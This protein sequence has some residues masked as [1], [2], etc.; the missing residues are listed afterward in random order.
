MNKL[1][2]GGFLMA[3]IH[4]VSGRIF[5]GRL[6]AAGIEINPAQGRI[7]FA[8]WQQDN[9]PIQT[10]RERTSLEKSTLTSMLDRLEEAGLVRRRPSSSD[11]RQLLIERTQK[12]RALEGAYKAV[13][14]GMAEVFYRGFK[15]EEIERFE[16][17]LRRIF[18][19]LEREEK[20]DKAGRG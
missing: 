13:S 6:R 20:E 7:L 5:S 11:R 1:R 10:L 19:N 9:I 16:S 8:L 14:R 17:Y 4:Q 12:D 15:D 3:R 2:P 18:E